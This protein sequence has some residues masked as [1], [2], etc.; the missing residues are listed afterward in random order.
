MRSTRSS[1]SFLL[2]R[3]VSPFSL[4]VCS[5]SLS[6]DLRWLSLKGCPHSGH[7]APSATFNASM[8]VF[9]S[10]ISRRNASFSAFNVA[11][12]SRASFLFFSSSARS[13]IL[14]SASFRDSCVTLNCFS[15]SETIANWSLITEY[16]LLSSSCSCS[17]FAF[18]TSISRSNG[19]RFSSC[20][21]NSAALLSNA[22]NSLRAFCHALYVDSISFARSTRSKYSARSFS[23]EVIFASIDASASCARFNCN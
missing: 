21:R 16:C 11:C 2:A 15:R 17:S 22:S 12:C 6:V 7:S 19:W 10:S 18:S 8:R 5:N 14:S 3:K 20:S 1:A 23:L 4:P 9:N 13:C